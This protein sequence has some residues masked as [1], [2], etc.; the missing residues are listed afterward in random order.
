MTTTA[1]TMA[2]KVYI[3]IGTNIGNR[4]QNLAIAKKEIEEFAQISKQSPIYETEPLGHKDQE[5]FY[6][7]VIEIKTI[8]S[9]KE[10]IIKLQEIE[11]KMGRIREI[12]NGPRVID[13][14]ILLYNREVINQPHLTIPHPRLH[15][16]SFVLDPL[17]EIAADL[18]H[19][20]LNQSID[21]LKHELGKNRTTCKRIT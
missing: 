8:L 19:P 3:A 4:Q 7:Q 14:D 1:H 20:S 2:N 16:R 17:S 18:I 12:K 21:S 13:L 9:A 15:K 11:H 5:S 6:N 10:L